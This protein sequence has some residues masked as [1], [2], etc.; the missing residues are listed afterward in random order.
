MTLSIKALL[1]E[2]EK[3]EKAETEDGKGKKRGSKKVE[4]DG[5]TE[6]REWKDAGDSGASIAELL[7]NN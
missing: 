6:L 4:N 7:G 1:P 2:V 3:P 5:E